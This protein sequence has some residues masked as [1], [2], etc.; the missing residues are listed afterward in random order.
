MGASDA[1]RRKSK[2][3]NSSFFLL[4]AIKFAEF[5]PRNFSRTSLRRARTF[6]GRTIRTDAGV[7][8]S[9][10]GAV[11]QR[12]PALTARQTSS[13]ERPGLRDDICRLYTKSHEQRIKPGARFSKNLMKIS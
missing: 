11:W 13:T 2:F 1:R 3:G 10:C 5:P 8:C 12:T 6:Y 4:L 9:R 7:R